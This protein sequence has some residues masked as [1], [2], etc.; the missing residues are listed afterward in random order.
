MQGGVD[1]SHLQYMACLMS[2][3][4][5]GSIGREKD[6]PLSGYRSPMPEAPSV[7]QEIQSLSGSLSA[8]PPSPVSPGG[9]PVAGIGPGGSPLGS[10]LGKR[11]LERV[12]DRE[13]P[14]QPLQLKKLRHDD[15]EDLSMRDNTVMMEA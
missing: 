4:P 13:S 10:P 3:S 7:K 15:P 1:E 5:N 14:D 6:S 9:S 11:S 2:G 8:G 12:L